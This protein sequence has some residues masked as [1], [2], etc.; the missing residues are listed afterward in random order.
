L[1]TAKGKELLKSSREKAKIK[2]S[3]VNIVLPDMHFHWADPACVSIA[4]LSIAVSQPSKVISL[5]DIIEA[6][7]FSSHKKKT[8][9]ENEGGYI[10]AEIYTANLFLDAIQEIVPTA[11]LIVLG[12]NHE[13][14]VEAFAASLPGAVA[15][16]V[17]DG[18]N[19]YKLLSRRVDGTQ[20][21]N[22]EVIPYQKALSHYEIAPDLWAIHG[23]FCGVNFCMDTLR[24]AAPISMVCG[25]AHRQQSVSIRNPVN[26]TI[27]KVFSPGTLS[28]LQPLW[29][30]PNPTDWVQGLSLIY[31][32]ADK[33]WT[34]YTV[35]IKDE[36]CVMPGGTQLH[37]VLR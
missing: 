19:P 16:A 17:L 26:N 10:D 23:W 35:T 37:A 13:A 20:R 3:V 4:L 25:H 31:I 21:K 22:F 14:R 34:D 24:K 30:A 36:K 18:C 15:S 11:E 9:K 1:K 5:G 33:S 2:G 28:L 27:R 29:N 7:A 6:G 12:G 8:I 32:G